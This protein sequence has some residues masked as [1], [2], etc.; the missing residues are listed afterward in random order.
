M[1]YEPRPFRGVRPLPCKCFPAGLLWRPAASFGCL[2]FLGLAGWSSLV[3]DDSDAVADGLPSRRRLHPQSCGPATGPAMILPVCVRADADGMVRGGA[4]WSPLLGTSAVTPSRI[5]VAE[6]PG[7]IFPSRLG[8][9]FHRRL[10]GMALQMVG[11]RVVVAGGRRHAPAALR[12][13]WG[14]RSAG[15]RGCWSAAR[16]C[17]MPCWRAA[18]AIGLSLIHI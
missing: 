16:T 7:R 1:V 9:Y 5:L 4:D 17:R 18:A 10:G 8:T 11:Q 14:C 12:R 2:C 6:K 3:G 13:G 15:L